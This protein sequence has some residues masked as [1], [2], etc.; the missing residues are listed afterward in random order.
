MVRFY[1]RIAVRVRDPRFATVDGN[2][3]LAKFQ[4][5]RTWQM[6]DHN[7]LWVQVKT[8]FSDSYLEQISTT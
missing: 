2:T 3:A 1:D 6:S 8:D 7:P 5:W 4:K